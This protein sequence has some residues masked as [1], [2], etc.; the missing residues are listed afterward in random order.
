M[1]FDRYIG[2]DY[3]GAEVPTSSLKGLRIYES[4]GLTPPR[5]VAPPK[6][7]RWYWTRREIAEWLVAELN[8]GPPSIVG[9]LITDSRSQSAIFK[10]MACRLTGL[11]FWMIFRNTPCYLTTNILTS[12][13]SATAF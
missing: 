11:Y 13:S 2:I 12:T 10:S 8:A 9:A 7:P 4:D 5:E 6:S 1:I 3:S